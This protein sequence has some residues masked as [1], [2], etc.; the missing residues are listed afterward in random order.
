[1]E[2]TPLSENV[3]FSPNVTFSGARFLTPYGRTVRGLFN[4][5][6]AVVW[7][8]GLVI[9]SRTWGHSLDDGK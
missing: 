8:V 5:V 2:Q 1:M 4:L 9:Y 3:T 6:E 7:L